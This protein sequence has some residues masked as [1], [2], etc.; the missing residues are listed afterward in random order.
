[1][2]R[3]LIVFAK[4]P[5]KDKVKT[6]LSTGLSASGCLN[7]YK[8]F[9]K[10]TINLVKNIRCTEKIL[11]YDSDG[12][13]PHYLRRIAPHFTFYQQ[14]GKD[15]GIRMH[16]AFKFAQKKTTAKTVILGSDSPSLPL[17]FIKKAFKQLEK[18]DLVVGPSLDGGYYL[19]GLKEPSI[20]L[21]KG[22]SWSSESVLE[23]T[24]KRAKVLKKKVA[25]LDRWY[26]VDS[27]EALQHLKADLKKKECRGSAKWT[28][29][30]LKI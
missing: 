7:L 16:N 6:R 14:K 17:N 23:D 19:I 18:C 25:L 28:K 27:P 9:L 24:I 3:R 5:T 8:A 4:E 11:A 30:F 26:D 1:M 2:K 12:Q 21:F 15:L 13:S 20:K 29:R 10:D 22:I